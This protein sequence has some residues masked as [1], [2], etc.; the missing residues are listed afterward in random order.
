MSMTDM[1]DNVKLLG[2]T[3]IFPEKNIDFLVNQRVGLIKAKKGIS[4]YPYIYCL[5]NNKTF[6]NDIRKRANSGVQVNL[7]TAG[8]KSTLTLAPPSDL[9][10]KFGT[11]ATPIF[12]KTFKLLSENQTLVELRDTLLPKLMSGELRVPEAEKLV[13]EAV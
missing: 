4:N 3:A 6:L 12:E 13:G 1:K 11:V 5:T 9:M 8:I 7:S 2:H 10:N